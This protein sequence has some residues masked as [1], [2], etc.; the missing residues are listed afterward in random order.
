MSRGLGTMQRDILRAY[1]TARPD[2]RGMPRVTG[3]GTAYDHGEVYSAWLLR[4]DVVT[5]RGGWCETP[6]YTPAQLAFFTPIGGTR[7]TLSMPW[8]GGALTSPL[9]VR[10]AHP[11]QAWGTGCSQG[12]WGVASGLSRATHP[13]CGAW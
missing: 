9:P 3:W 8:S 6:C 10:C 11:G 1:A 4:V 12:E 2:A 13:L 7:R 5:L